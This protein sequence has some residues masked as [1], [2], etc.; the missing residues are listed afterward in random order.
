M[1][2]FQMEIDD[3]L[4]IVSHYHVIEMYLPVSSP[5]QCRSGCIISNDS[6]TFG[7]LVYRNS[8]IVEWYSYQLAALVD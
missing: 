1:G 8:P 3:H 6:M 2:I 4:K 5:S 7:S